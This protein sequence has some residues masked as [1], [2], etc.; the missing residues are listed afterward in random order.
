MESLLG[1]TSAPISRISTEPASQPEWVVQ[2]EADDPPEERFE[3]TILR[4][5]HA[6][7]EALFRRAWSLS[8]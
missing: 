3:A 7:L 6:A 2:P 4:L 8:A 5:D 1:L